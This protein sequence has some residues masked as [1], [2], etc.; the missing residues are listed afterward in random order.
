MEARELMQLSGLKKNPGRKDCQPICIFGRR[1]II[2]LERVYHT[3]SIAV[4]CVIGVIAS[5]LS[6]SGAEM[7]S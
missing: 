5:A 2:L 1:H 6:A 7:G 4:L 3:N